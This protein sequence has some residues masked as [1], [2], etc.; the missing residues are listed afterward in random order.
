MRF[1]LILLLGTYSSVS[2][3]YL[4]FCVAFYAL[5][6]TA[7][8]PSLEGVASCRSVPWVDRMC[9][10]ALTDVKLE[11]AQAGRSRG[12]LRGATLAGQLQLQ[13]V[14]TEDTWA[15]WL[16]LVWPGLGGAGRPR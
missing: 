8:S 4:T 13:R 9:L 12:T 15:G 14:C 6:E 16:E 3:L 1:Y 5:E 10:V 11:P 7:T 2:S